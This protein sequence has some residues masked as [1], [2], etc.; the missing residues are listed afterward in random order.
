MR[1]SWAK[2]SDS[3]IAQW[4]ERCTYE[5]TFH[6][7][8]PSSILGGTSFLFANNVIISQEITVIIVVSYPSSLTAIRILLVPARAFFGA[9]SI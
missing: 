1:H 3:P 6:A 5:V 2:P 4:S 8:V 7:R 9:P